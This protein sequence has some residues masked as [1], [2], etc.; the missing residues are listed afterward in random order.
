[1]CVYMSRLRKIQTMAHSISGAFSHCS[2]LPGKVCPLQ[3]A[4][5]QVSAIWSRISGQIPYSAITSNRAPQSCMTILKIGHHTTPDKGS[6]TPGQ[7]L[8]GRRLPPVQPKGRMPGA[9]RSRCSLVWPWKRRLLYI[10]KEIAEKDEQK[11][12]YMVRIFWH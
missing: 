9:E 1:M 6:Q 12:R 4:L 3:L 10:C 2:E 11:V 5:S 8:C 7:L